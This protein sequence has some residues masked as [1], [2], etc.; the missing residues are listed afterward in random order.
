MRKLGFNKVLWLVQGYPSSRW[1][2][3]P[4]CITTTRSCTLRLIKTWLRDFPGDPVVKNPPSN[5]GDVG[6]IP[7][8]GTKIPHAMG[9][10]S[11]QA[12]TCLSLCASTREP[13]CCKLQSPC[14]LVPIA[15]TGPTTT[16][17]AKWANKYIFLKNS[18]EFYFVFFCFIV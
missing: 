18:V 1:Q 2:Q 10:L 6:S 3:S 13:A 8:W 5:A 15:T 16:K 17:A 4:R 7:G 14:A 9:Q 11:L 12:T